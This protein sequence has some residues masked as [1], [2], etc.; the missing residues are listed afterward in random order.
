MDTSPVPLYPARAELNITTIMIVKTV[1]SHCASSQPLLEIASAEEN[2]NIAAVA[3]V[4]CVCTKTVSAMIKA[5]RR[6]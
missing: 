2:K 6:T 5:K 3:A 4:G 1:H